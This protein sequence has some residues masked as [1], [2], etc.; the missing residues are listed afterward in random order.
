LTRVD[1]T[2]RG[3]GIFGLSI[4]H[5][6]AMRGAV[7]RV[8]DPGG[9]GAGASGGIVG[10]LA[11]HVP[12]QW[13]AKKAFQLDSL[14]LAATWWADVARIGGADPGY[15]RTG[16]LQPLADA[17]AVD[18]ARAR[19][20]EAATLWQGRAAWSVVPV[21]GAAWEPQSPS[22][23]L[24]HDTLTARIHPRLALAALAAAIR[25]MGGSIVADAP[26][27][28]AVIHATG[29]HGL[30]AL[31]DDLGRP[32]GGAVKGQA[33]ALRYDAAALPQLF[34]DGLHIVPHADGTVAVGST[35]ENRWEDPT[36][37]DA[38]LDTLHAAAIAAVPALAA[39]P[40][41]TRW[42]ALRPRAALRAPV[43]GPWPGRPGH[44]IAN[45]GFKIG[46]GMAPK[47][48]DVMADLVLGGTDAIP[49]AFR[50]SAL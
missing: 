3:A 34:I 30:Q 32:V 31:S 21:T 37:T 29:I 17:R 24:V 33:L 28:G 27:Q 15:A 26:D 16:R 7:V 10:A 35:S 49:E 1:V 9:M 45:G 38:Q 19:G 39:A 14:L 36:G 46:F 43:L 18:A 13:N 4:A 47:I 41:V 25:A 44:F 48:A 5:A 20:R 40:V 12:E 6:S 50:V 22:G 2:V 42:A 8:V 23:L 11:P